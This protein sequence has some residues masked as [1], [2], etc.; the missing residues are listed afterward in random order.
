M[1][2]NCDDSL[3]VQ[4]D[5]S[6]VICTQCGTETP[7]TLEPHEASCTNFEFSPPIV[8]VYSRPDRW[9]TIVSKVVG[10]HQGPPTKDPVWNYLEKR[11]H[12]FFKPTDILHYLRISGLKNKHYQCLHTFAKAFLKSYTPPRAHPTVVETYLGIYF[13][14]INTIWLR[15]FTQTSPFISYAW[16][17]EQGLTFY[18]FREYLPYL[19]KLMCHTRR[20]KYVR[21]LR[22][23]FSKYGIHGEMMNRGWKD[24]HSLN[25]SILAENHHNPQL[26]P[27]TPAQL[28]DAHYRLSEAREPSDWV[29][30]LKGMCSLPPD[31]LEEFAELLELSQGG[32]AQHHDLKENPRNG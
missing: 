28:H 26:R 5:Y 11:K 20:M 1:P 30:N 12:K 29:Q 16:L 3:L 9:K 32:R 6:T 21:T 18:G 24:I 19:K 27:P 31:T 13:D 22:T 14:I 8:R 2:C 15:H 7:I 4:S 17:L 10:N 23:L 25:E